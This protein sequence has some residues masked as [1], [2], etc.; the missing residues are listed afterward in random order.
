M[1]MTDKRKLQQ[2][3][4]NYFS[5]IWFKDFIKLHNDYTK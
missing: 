4:L 1:G 3:A 2:R 5:D